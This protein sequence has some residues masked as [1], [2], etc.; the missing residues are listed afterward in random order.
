[1]VDVAGWMT[2]FE[3]AQLTGSADDVASLVTADAVLLPAPDAD[4][5]SGR[6]AIVEWWPSEPEP[7][8]TEFEWWPVVTTDTTAHGRGDRPAPILRR[9]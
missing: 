6:D 8:G 2:R 1:M 7:P 5:V 9:S 4:P 3:R